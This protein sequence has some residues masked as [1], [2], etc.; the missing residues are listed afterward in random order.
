MKLGLNK[1]LCS[2]ELNDIELDDL[3]GNPGMF[4]IL[5]FYCL[6]EYNG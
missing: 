3:S 4:I 1:F 5:I 2:I 6:K